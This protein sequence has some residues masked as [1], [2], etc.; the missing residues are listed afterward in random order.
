MRTEEIKGWQ[1]SRT[2]SAADLNPGAR[3]QRI[4]I[5]LIARV[6][7]VNDNNGIAPLSTTVCGTR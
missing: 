2:S 3:H 4:G 1:M 7:A 6:P 5:G